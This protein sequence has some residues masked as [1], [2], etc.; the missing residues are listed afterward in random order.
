MRTIYFWI[1]FATSIFTYGIVH[2][3][4]NSYIKINM[5]ENELSIVLEEIVSNNKK[6]CDESK[7]NMIRMFSKKPS[8][9]IISQLHMVQKSI[10]LLR[11]ELDQMRDSSYQR[12]NFA[13]ESN[14]AEIVSIFDTKMEVRDFFSCLLKSIF[15]D[16]CDLSKSPRNLIKVFEVMSDH[17]SFS[18]NSV[19][20]T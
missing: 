1:I 16:G 8:Y 4:L 20:T 9:T 7:P 6:E 11:N 3:I 18:L 13:L 14:G 19:F 5:I 12:P 2:T 17:S 10:D 15:K